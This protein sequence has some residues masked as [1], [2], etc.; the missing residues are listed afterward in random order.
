MV[1]GGIYE[2]RLQRV[3]HE[4][5]SRL[6]EI[7]PKAGIGREQAL[8]QLRPPACAADEVAAGGMITSVDPSTRLPKVLPVVAPRAKVTRVS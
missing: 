5:P 4:A 2:L 6:P 3:V 1:F 7:P 8:Q